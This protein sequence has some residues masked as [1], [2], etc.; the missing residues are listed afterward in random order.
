MGWATSAGKTAAKYGAKYGP[1]AVVVWKVAGHHVEA[2]ARNKLDEVGARRTAFDHASTVS[3]GAVLRV[4][5]SGHAV[6]VV[7]SG[8]R[9][10][11]SYPQGDKPLEALL[12]DADLRR[13]VTPEQHRQQRLRSRL[14]RRAS[15]QPRLPR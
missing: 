11:A 10:V 14:Q 8:E 1:H 9:A 12:R 15:R 4:V 5:D 3:D 7:L 2:A 13:R 6:F